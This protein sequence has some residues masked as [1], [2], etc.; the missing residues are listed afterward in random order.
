MWFLIYIPLFLSV[1]KKGWKDNENRCVGWGGGGRGCAVA[2]L[3]FSHVQHLGQGKAKRRTEKLPMAIK[4]K[5]F[6]SQTDMKCIFLFLPRRHGLIN[7]R[8]AKP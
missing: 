2:L 8:D 3:T 7:Y 5:P 6:G 1:A 4:E